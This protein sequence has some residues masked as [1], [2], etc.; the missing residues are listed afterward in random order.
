MSDQPDLVTWLRQ[1]LDEDER[2]APLTMQ[3]GAMRPSTAWVTERLADEIAAKRRILDL[4]ATTVEK[5]PRSPFNPMTGEPQGPQFSAYCDLCGWA[6]D[7]P[8]SAC[9]TVRLLAL[10]FADRP[11]YRQEWAP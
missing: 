11:G 1:Q 6:A 2:R 8:L 3:I 9:E 10:P 5:G 7:D 4:H